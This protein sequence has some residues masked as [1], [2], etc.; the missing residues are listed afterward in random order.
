MPR[1]AR[2]VVWIEQSSTI[3]KLESRIH[4]NNLHASHRQMVRSVMRRSTAAVPPCLDDLVVADTLRF[5]GLAEG[6]VM[7]V[8]HGVC[9]L[10]A[11]H[12]CCP[13]LQKRIPVLVLAHYPLALWHRFAFA[14]GCQDT[15]GSRFINLVTQRYASALVLDN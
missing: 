15:V 8:K 7:R 11:S 3:R 9:R 2:R 5:H 6:F 14:I 12:R 1:A 10:G 13:V 4:A